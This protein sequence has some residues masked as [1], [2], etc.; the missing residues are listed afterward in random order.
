M[1]EWLIDPRNPGEVLACAGIAHL[2]WRADGAAATGFVEA[3]EGR[4][5]FVAPHA[6]PPLKAL[7]GA[8]L[9]PVGESR[10]ALRLGA[11]ALDWWRPWGLNPRLKLWAGRQSAW[12]VHRSLRTAAGDASPTEWL[13]DCAPAAGRLYIDPAGT[14]NARSLG[15]SI[16]AHPHLR[17]RARPWLELLASVGLQAFPVEGHRARGGFHFSLWRPAPLAAA[18]AA[19]AGRFSP[20]YALARYHVPTAKSGTNTVLRAA[21]PVANGAP[22]PRHDRRQR[23][24]SCH[25]RSRS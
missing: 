9:E 1:A 16:D 10:A 22:P 5:R 15:F 7:H 2:A 18:V 6:P 20:T 14:W 25:H 4:V 8:T 12:S 13:T 21:T 3:G 17:M 23:R 11:I 24:E 19:F